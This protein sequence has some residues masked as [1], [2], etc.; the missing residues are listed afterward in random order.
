MICKK[1]GA[2]IAETSKFCGYCGNQMEIEN[3]TVNTFNNVNEVNSQNVNLEKNI[4]IGQEQP[5]VNMAPIQEQTVNLNLQAQ[6]VIE[7]P[8]PNQGQTPNKKNNNLILL[9]S[10]I[11]VTLIGV[12][13]IIVS[14]FKTNGASI[15]VLQ[16]AINNLNQVAS[17]SLT[18]KGKLSL[19]ATTGESFE[20][21]VSSKVQKKEDKYN[22]ELMLEKSMFFD[23]IKL[24]GTV[25]KDN[26]SLYAK[27]SL[28]DMLGSTSS[29]EDK[30]VYYTLNLK[31]LGVDLS[32]LEQNTELQ[33]T[34]NNINLEDLIDKKHFLYI[35]K[36]DGL[37]HYQLV[38]DQKLIENIITKLAE[39]SGETIDDT[40]D[41]TEE[42]E[43]TIKIDFYIN[44]SDELAKIELNM[45][46]YL[47]E[48]DGLSKLVFTLEFT[49]LNSTIVEIPNE[50]ITSTMDL[51]TYMNSNAVET[52][53]YDYE[54]DYDYD[55]NF[56]GALYEY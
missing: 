20:I 33:Q 11:L 21:N 34:F 15:T 43:E 44:N 31:E 49:G 1:C 37:K 30:W 28:I 26:I 6:Q 25:S 16:K 42:L 29:I 46:D 54:F 13:I 39:M 9:T 5:I 24:Y 10:G 8:I 38:I 17:N 27:S 45:S 56:D 47:T 41:M 36:K 52:D 7:Q 35:G 51:E 32:T 55:I 4:P 50:A 12:I 18:V 23:E 19:A 53:D 22:M 48:E 2:N 14:I 40:V 3:Q